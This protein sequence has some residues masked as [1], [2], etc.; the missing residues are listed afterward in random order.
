MGSMKTSEILG[1]I[2]EVSPF[3]EVDGSG[4]RNSGESANDVA[5]GMVFGSGAEDDVEEKRA[6]SMAL[7]YEDADNVDEEKDQE[8]IE[9]FENI[10]DIIH[11]YISNI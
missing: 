2:G 8:W 1:E 9:D 5:I 11:F 3:K 6:K 4:G 7:L 10:L